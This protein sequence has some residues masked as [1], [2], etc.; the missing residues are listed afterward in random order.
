M[1]LELVVDEV[2]YVIE[3]DRE[4]P[5][6][7]LGE[8]DYPVRLLEAEGDRIEIEIAGEK[9]VVQGWPA[10]T[11]RPTGPLSVN[12]EVVRLGTLLRSEVGRAAPPAAAPSGAPPPTGAATGA[13]P[14][15]TAG[16]DDGPGIPLRPPM[17][18]KV[19][20]L[21][22]QNGERVASGQVLLVLEAMKMRNEVASPA[23]G[24]V[25]GMTVAVGTSVRA[26]DILLRIL[27]SE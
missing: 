1:R 27:P 18:G 23:D 2:R 20:E 25:Q 7:R 5:T 12:G 16:A 17:P 26:K 22:V 8:V 10:R 9:V 21:R 4:A 3:F 6:I 19:L 15:P 13:A 24:V 14:R 11:E